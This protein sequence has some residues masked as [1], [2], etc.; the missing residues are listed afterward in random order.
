MIPS[1]EDISLG[2]RGWH[3]FRQ[4][5]SSQLE[6]VRLIGYCIHSG[7]ILPNRKLDSVK[8]HK[9]YRRGVEHTNFRG[10][11]ASTPINNYTNITD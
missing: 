2:G 1:A 3:N 8:T 6:R 7:M 4:G 5:R 11:I 9:G 10:R